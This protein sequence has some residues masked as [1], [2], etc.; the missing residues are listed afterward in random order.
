MPAKSRRRR[1][2]SNDMTQL[3]GWNASKSAAN[4]AISMPTRNG[5]ALAQQALP[6]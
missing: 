4:Q 5:S 3:E 6:H 1:L 2:C